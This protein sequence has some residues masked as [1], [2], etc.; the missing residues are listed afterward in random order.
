MW[1]ECG[2]WLVD[3]Y[4][5]PTACVGR[6]GLDVH[7]SAA[8]LAGAGCQAELLQADAGG[9]G[10]AGD[11]G[12]AGDTGALSDAGDAGSDAGSDVGGDT[13]GD[14]AP[15]RA[16]PDG[17]SDDSSG[18]GDAQLDADAAGGDGSDAT[19][20]DGADGETGDAAVDPCAAKVCDD[21]NP[22]ITD[23]CK[24][25]A[26]AALPVAATPCDDG[27]ACTKA[28][29]CD[30]GVCKGAPT[31]AYDDGDPSLGCKVK[32]KAAN[33]A[34]DNGDSCIIGETCD[35]GGKCKGAPKVCNDNNICTKDACKRGACT[36][37]DVDGIPCEDGDACTTEDRCKG[38]VCDAGP[39]AKC[40]DGNVCTKD[41]CAGGLCKTE[42]LSSISCDDLNECTVGDKCVAGGCDPGKA[43]NCD[44]GNDCT[45]DGCSKGACTATANGKACDDGAVCTAGDACSAKACGGSQLSPVSHASVQSCTVLNVSNYPRHAF[46]RHANGTIAV[47]GHA[48][49][50]TGLLGLGTSVTRMNSSGQAIGQPT[51]L[52]LPETNNDRPYLIAT[53]AGWT[54]VT[55][56]G[57]SAPTLMAAF[58]LA[59]GSLDG[60]L[61]LPGGDPATLTVFGGSTTAAGSTLIGTL[62]KASQPGALAKVPSV[63]EVSG[64]ALVSTTVVASSGG[65]VKYLLNVTGGFLYIKEDYIVVLQAIGSKGSTWEV[66]GSR[67]A[68]T[69]S[70]RSD[71]PAS[72]TS[73]PW[74]ATCPVPGRA[75]ARRF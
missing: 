36:T 41:S 35:A 65:S 68:T 22:C 10:A 67:Q 7:R 6:A 58:M 24:D 14:A 44:D 33:S 32:A 61:K 66:Q 30:A 63:L 49:C 45:D 29:S 39:A 31:P 8:A 27:D 15:D 4:P 1:A 5:I 42:P 2:G 46:G 47:V 60:T 69:S 72:R 54:I 73:S 59:D 19:N 9:A 37:T 38:G 64:K 40:D 25:G 34:C 18:S 52:W 21:K 26:C 11:S 3:R 50:G 51:P 75:Q 57:G 43:K 28:D 70:R 53:P 23:G 20:D 16:D 17:S 56:T 48:K 13:G 74:Q 71:R 55:R 12:G 62:D